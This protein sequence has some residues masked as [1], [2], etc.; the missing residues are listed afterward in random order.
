LCLSRVTGEIVTLAAHFL[1]NMEH[2]IAIIENYLN[3]YNRFD[4]DQMLADCHEQIVF[5]NIT[6]GEVNMSLTGLP[7]FRSQAEQAKAYFSI[8]NQKATSYKHESDRT[9]VQIDYYAVAA[10]DFPNGLHKGDELRLQG[11]SIFQF[12]DGKIVRITDLS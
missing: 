4:V 7:A 12:A 1:V 5:E 8:R 6:G 2:R 3:A 10:M 9:E 11:M